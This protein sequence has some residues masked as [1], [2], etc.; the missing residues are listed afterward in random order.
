MMSGL[1]RVLVANPGEIALRLIRAC[2]D[3]GIEAVAV[4]SKADAQARWVR[5]ADAA[6]PIGGSPA[7]KSYLNIEAVLEAAAES[8]ADAVHP[9]YGFLAESADFARAV[10]ERSLVFIG[11][12]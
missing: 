4:Y 6:Y 8:R 12:P 11:P 7:S 10:D 3:A 5:L 9:G 2:H 1:R